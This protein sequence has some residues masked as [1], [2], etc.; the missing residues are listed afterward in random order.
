MFS[1]LRSPTS[2]SS[3]FRGAELNGLRSPSAR[4]DSVPP[5]PTGSTGSSA[6]HLSG[7]QADSVKVTIRV[8]PEE[9]D[10]GRFAGRVWEVDEFGEPP[11]VTL[12]SDYAERYRKPA[13]EFFFDNVQEGSDNKKLYEESTQEVVHAAMEGLNA[14]VFAYGQTASGK[15]YSMI[16]VDE[17]PGVIP[18]AVDD[19]FNYIREQ[20]EDRE[21][22]L[23]VSYMEIY[24]ETIKDLLAPDSTDL[25][26]HEDRKRGIFVSPL[27]EEIVTSPKQV[28]KIIRKGE[29]NRHVGTTDYNLHSSRSHAIFQ[30]IIESRDRSVP[31][32][33]SRRGAPPGRARGAVTISHLNLIDL[34][35]SE[36]AATDLERRK[37]GAYINKSL[38]TLGTVISRLTDEKAW[39]T[40]V[41]FRDS[42]LTRILQNSLSGN[43]RVS[44]ICTISATASNFEETTSTLKFAARV[45]KVVVR[46]QANRVLD[47]KA[48]IQKYRQEIED[49]KA[50]LTESNT[51]L[52]KERKFQTSARL[53][54]ERARFEEQLH[55]SQ[56]ARTALKERIDHLTKLILTSQ[57]ITPKGILDW[58]TPAEAGPNIRASVMMTEGLLPTSP[59]A[60]LGSPNA[61]GISPQR[62]VSPQRTPDR[63][64]ARQTRLARHLND[65][66]FIKKHI[67]EIDIRDQRIK[68][69]ELLI[70]MLKSSRDP[71]VQSTI[72]NFEKT[73]GASVKSTEELCTELENSRKQI[74]EMDVVIREQDE[75]IEMMGNQ[76]NELRRALQ[77]AQPQPT[78][79][80]STDDKVEELTMAMMQQNTEL[81]AITKSEAALR[82]A[83]AELGNLVAQHRVQ[84]ET[85]VGEV[86]RLKGTVAELQNT[87]ARLELEKEEMS[88]KQSTGPAS[89]G[90]GGGYSAGRLKDLELALER[91]RRMRLE[92]QR[93]STERIAEMEAELGML[94]AELSVAQLSANLTK[95]SFR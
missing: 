10:W 15:T 4:S 75:K 14:T 23:R 8:R 93:S 5:S 9:V 45:K 6:S 78:N 1:A 42:K 40:H 30:M 16:G 88:F 74:G 51:M 32:T 43:A 86:K 94:K 68:Q 77:L 13:T 90:A 34:A 18:Q 81:E 7:G 46:A 49:L 72:G 56:M 95:T 62:G 50:K 26:I 29:E 82:S 11:K 67:Q 36:K 22:L 33:P 76:V 79:D 64:A 91:E 12:A 47:E 3:K 54:S 70:M 28:M 60:N 20:S 27:K 2:F 53:E 73:I 87:V 85:A 92:E 66:E 59:A 17:Q 84:M 24:N 37:E 31:V 52:E 44:V 58:N 61:R 57:S 55:E 80:S 39:G 89:P 35:G 71:M 41:P 21:Y 19:I 65:G 25:R 83:N 63:L 38:L 48:L 69:L